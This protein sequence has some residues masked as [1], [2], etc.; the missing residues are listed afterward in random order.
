MPGKLLSLMRKESIRE[1]RKSSGN[2]KVSIPLPDKAKM[3]V[4]EIIGS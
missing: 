3:G 1:E 4:L 2:C